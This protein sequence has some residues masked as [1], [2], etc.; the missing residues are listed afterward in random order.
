VYLNTTESLRLTVNG[1]H[2]SFMGT[3]KYP[4][5]N[6]YT[7]YLALHS[8]SFNAHTGAT[9]TVPVYKSAPRTKITIEAADWLH[10]HVLIIN[11]I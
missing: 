6:A 3:E 8:G 1:R 11:L 5:E 4:D 2:L 10:N 7:K 9:S